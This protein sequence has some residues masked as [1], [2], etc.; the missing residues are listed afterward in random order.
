MTLDGP[1]RGNIASLLERSAA[2]RAGADAIVALDGRPIWS[3]DGLAD[4]AARLAGGL[5][6]LG[7]HPGDRVLVLETRLLELYLTVVGV[8]WAGGAVVIPPA[9]LPLR[10]ALQAAAASRPRAVIASLPLWPIAVAS[11]S[12]RSAPIRVTNAGWPF[13]GTVRASAL[14]HH[15]AI[16]PRPVPP[17][18]PAIVSF[19]TGT[20]GPTKAIER[21]H[22]VLA[23]QHSALTAL[24]RLDDTDLD[25]VGLPVLV[26][27]NLGAGVASVPAPREAGSPQY[28]RRVRDAI[29]RTR[30]TSAAGFPHLFE[31]SL[32]E[33]GPGDLDSLR[34]LHVGGSRVRPELLTG[35]RAAAPQARVT[36]VYGST[37]VEPI[38]AIEG[39]ENLNR[40]AGSD[41]A[42]GVCV[43][44]VLGD[45]EFRVEP[46]M[47]VT[48][49]VSPPDVA[50]RVEVRGARASG[51][52]QTAGWVDTG[53]LGRIDPDGRLW[54]LGR[55]ANAI[56]RLS[57][58]EV[59]RAVEAMPW[60]ARAALVVRSPRGESHCR[61]AVEP[62]SWPGGDVRRQWLHSVERLAA[63][64]H[65][66]LQDVVLV[67]RLPVLKGASAKIDDRRIARLRTARPRSQSPSKTP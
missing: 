61:L 7:L 24:R 47:P 36:V 56:G 49:A 21:T 28:G 52:D 8:I 53:D 67:R 26:L 13:P 11:G 44:F 66:P 39:G 30:P 20:T 5:V 14:S 57:P 2:R 41:A 1:A 4:A 38:A 40:L 10:R 63:E 18:S 42:D 29:V 65:W 64:R 27:H 43:G 9:S 33:A 35:L 34:T 16:A 31:T 23:A 62:R 55:A 19:T 60:V 51:G 37:E 6:E 45:L 59:E 50:G 3:F 32:R 15:A 48:D 22:G 12:L 46:R 17:N 54:L 25:L 58:S